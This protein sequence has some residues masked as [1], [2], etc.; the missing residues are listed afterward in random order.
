MCNCMA[1]RYIRN[2]VTAEEYIDWLVEN[3]KIPSL[4]DDLFEQLSIML[5]EIDTKI[6]GEV[7]TVEDVLIKYNVFIGGKLWE[8]ERKTIV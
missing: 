3:L 6:S 7:Q 2:E 1:C 8:E 5:Y 4:S